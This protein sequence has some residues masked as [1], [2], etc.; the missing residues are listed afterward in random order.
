MAR[1]FYAG[2]KFS[3]DHLVRNRWVN[4]LFS[5]LIAGRTGPM[6]CLLETLFPCP[7]WAFAR[8]Q[9]P[10]PYSVSEVRMDF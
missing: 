4:E 1:L 2:P 7:V 8:A 3:Y 6:R 9:K 5:R 10:A